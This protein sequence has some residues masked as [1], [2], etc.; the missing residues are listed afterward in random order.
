MTQIC[1]N[2]SEIA[3]LINKNP[4]KTQEDGIYDV[5]CR[6]TKTKNTK[7]LDKFDIINKDELEKLLNLFN[8]E[9]L[10]NKETYEKLEKELKEEKNIKNISKKLFKNISKES[11][12][13][14]CTN[15][16][17]IKQKKIEE[18]LDN[19]VKKNTTEVKQYVNGFINKQR[20]VKNENKIIEKYE[21][22]NNTKITNNNS[23]LYKIK[24]FD[25]ENNS[26]YI[27]GKIDGIENN[28]LIEVK[29]RRN[30]LFTFIPEYEKI[31][32]EIYF[33][34]TNLTKGKLI[35]NYND[36]QSTFEININND[37]WSSILEDLYKVSQIIISQLTTFTK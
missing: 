18:K 35:Q 12:N 36:T 16:S 19:I 24:I 14:K 11:I 23:C 17:K 20:G 4:Y 25:I 34:L 6:I 5:L 30:R 15:E 7:D 26:I 33:R 10:I 22:R 32:T 29:N 31:Q 2:A 3:T 37:L 8:K 21:N 28:E 9:Q 13:T 1:F 27:C